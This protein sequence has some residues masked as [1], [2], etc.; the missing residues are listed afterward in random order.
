MSQESFKNFV[1]MKN[2]TGFF[3]MSLQYT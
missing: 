3:Q 2:A 1:H